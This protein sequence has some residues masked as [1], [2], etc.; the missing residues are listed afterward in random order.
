MTKTEEINELITMI[1]NAKDNYRNGKTNLGN[2]LL[3]CVKRRVKEVY[4]I[5]KQVVVNENKITNNLLTDA[6]VREIRQEIADGV[7]NRTIAIS[8]GLADAVISNI[9]LGRTYRHVK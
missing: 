4:K 3:D 8:F 9:K 6:E 2:N 1:D 5:D 7:S